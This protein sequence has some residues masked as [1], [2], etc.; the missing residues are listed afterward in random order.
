MNHDSAE[1]FLGIDLT[2]SEAKASGCALLDSNGS[3]LEVVAARADSDILALADRLNPSI[4]AMDSPLGLPTGMCCLEETCPCTSVHPFKGRQCEQEMARRGIPL[5]FTTKR[6]IIKR[7]TYRAI[8]LAGALTEKGCRVLEVYPYASK[9]ALF[10]KPIPPKTTRE[11][12][13]FLRRRLSRLIPGVD[14]HRDALDHDLCDA[15]VA[16][17]TAYLHGL[18]R[19]EAVGL[20]EE[21]CIVMPKLDSGPS[22]W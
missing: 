1:I 8:E 10:G 19:T 12:I 16:A 4:V 3:L 9:L 14:T 2:S 6:S 20:P 7:M 18:G 21:V 15:L 5:Y 17:Y 11:G 22:P 13:D